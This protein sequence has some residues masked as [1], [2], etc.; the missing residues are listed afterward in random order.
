MKNASNDALNYFILD[1]L[2]S[3]RMYPSIEDCSSYVIFCNSDLFL[4]TYCEV[5]DFML[6]IREIREIRECQTIKLQYELKV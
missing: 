5:V 2:N 3:A 4:E 1:H 6:L